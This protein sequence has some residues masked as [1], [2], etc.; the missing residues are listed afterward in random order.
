[1]KKYTKVVV[2]ALAL[3]M[4]LFGGQVLAGNGKGSNG[5]Q[6]G[7]T[8]AGDRDQTKDGSCL[9]SIMTGA[10]SL[11]LAGQNGNRSGDQ[12]GAGDKGETKDGSCLDS[13]MTG[14]DFLLLAGQNGNR[15][16]DQ[17]G[18]GDK[19]ETKDGSCLEA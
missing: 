3:S 19:G 4:T 8:G 13:I 15:S 18:T 5:S 14:A 1:M 12:D 9:E 10:D 2:A 6:N 11:L 16:G 7:G 17:D